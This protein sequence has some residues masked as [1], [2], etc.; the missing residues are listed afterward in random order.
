MRLTATFIFMLALAAL[1]GC[2]G[3]ERSS[4]A[5][6]NV[7]RS[8][9]AQGEA[10]RAPQASEG[11]AVVQNVS[12]QQADAA[13]NT[14]ATIERKIIRNANVSL[15]VEEPKKAMQRVASVAESRGGFVVTSE[16]R[17]EAGASGG[18]ASEVISMEVRVPAAQFDAAM[19]DIRA[20]A[21]RVASEKIT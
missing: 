1:V 10:A 4:M 3:G 6:A 11:Q 14:P 21:S 12:L 18:K 8:S 2:G 13:Q 16:S 9:P 7:S 19:N 20:A 17:Q 5:N 15:E